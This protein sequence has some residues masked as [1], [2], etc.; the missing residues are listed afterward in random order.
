LRRG[1][2]ADDAW[3][4]LEHLPDGAGVDIPEFGQLWYSEVR[5]KGGRCGGFRARFLHGTS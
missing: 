5:L 3:F 1:P 4:V 2:E